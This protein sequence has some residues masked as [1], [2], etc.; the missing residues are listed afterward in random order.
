MILET[1]LHW[2]SLRV[3][4]EKSHASFISGRIFERWALF[5]LRPA[6]LSWYLL[7]SGS[8]WSRCGR[9]FA[10]LNTSW[11]FGARPPCWAR[12]YRFCIHYSAQVRH[13]LSTQEGK[14]HRSEGKHQR[15]GGEQQDKGYD[16][17]LQ[18]FQSF[19]Q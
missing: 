4:R 10:F 8:F 2:A 9:H 5:L 7:V 17:H 18:L 16:E 15:T 13:F 1:A 12:S 19:R 6:L 3:R 11:V 14:M